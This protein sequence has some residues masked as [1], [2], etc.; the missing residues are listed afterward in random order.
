[1]SA[2]IYCQFVTQSNANDS[3]AGLDLIGLADTVA[4][5]TP[6]EILAQM[7]EGR[8]PLYTLVVEVRTLP[9]VFKL[10][11]GQGFISPTDRKYPLQLR[12]VTPLGIALDFSTS[13]QSRRPTTRRCSF[14]SRTSS[15]S[16]RCQI[17][18][19]SSRWKPGSAAA[20]SSTPPAAWNKRHE[21]CVRFSGSC[22]YRKYLRPGHF[23]PAGS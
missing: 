6:D 5:G 13:T 12:R 3:K 4:L 15:T 7:E 22:Q 21:G 8:E 2:T 10:L 16:P 23:R 9:P 19:T 17:D 14:H 1:M 18:L 11:E 20:G